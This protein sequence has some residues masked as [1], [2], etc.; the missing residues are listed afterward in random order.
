MDVERLVEDFA[1]FVHEH[2]SNMD[3]IRQR[4]TTAVGVLTHTAVAQ[5]PLYAK[6]GFLKF[7]SFSNAEIES[8][9][10]QVSERDYLQFLEAL[11][12]SEPIEVAL[13][14]VVSHTDGATSAAGATVVSTGAGGGNAYQQHGGAVGGLYDDV[15]NPVASTLGEEAFWRVG[16]LVYA[17][18]GDG[19]YYPIPFVG[20][21][22]SRTEDILMVRHQLA[23][24]EYGPVQY[25]T[26][27]FKGVV[28]DEFAP[29]DL[30]T[31][32]LTVI[33][34]WPGA[35]RGHMREAVILAKSPESLHPDGNYT[36]D[37]EWTHDSSIQ[38]DV[39]FRC[40]RL[41]QHPKRLQQELA[42]AAIVRSKSHV[43]AKSYQ[44]TTSFNSYPTKTPPTALMAS[45]S[46]IVSEIPDYIKNFVKFPH[47]DKQVQPRTLRTA[48]H[49]VAQYGQFYYDQGVK[50][51]PLVSPSQLDGS[52]AA[53]G[54]QLQHLE[55]HA[56]NTK[57]F[58][59]NPIVDIC[60][61]ACRNDAMFVDPDFPPTFY[62]ITGAEEVPAGVVW[63]R[64]SELFSKPRLF[65]VGSK[66]IDIKPGRF[67][68]PW[69]IGLFHALSSVAEIEEMISPGE[70][71]WAFGA[72]AVKLFLDGE[73]S[74]YSITGA[75]EVP[76]GVVWRRLSE[77]FSK[78]RLFSVGSKAIDIKPGRFS[79]PWL[80]GLFHA[81][82]SVAE[83]EEMIS[84]GEDG[85][86]FGAYAVKLFLDGEWSFTIVDDFVPCDEETGEPLSCT[87]GT[88]DIY[89]AILEKVLAKLAGSYS[90]LR[91]SP[92]STAAIAWEDL[93]SNIL[94]VVDHRLLIQKD[95]LSENLCALISAGTNT[96]VL[97]RVR[98]EEERFEDIG[99]LREDHWF[100]DAVAQYHPPGRR[101]AMYFFHVC[102]PTHVGREVPYVESH[103]EKFYMQFPPDAV[104]H[105]PTRGV[106]DEGIAYWI[107][108][109]D[110]YSIFDRTLTFWFYNNTQRAAIEAT[111]VGRSQAAPKM[112]G[113]SRWLA[114]PQ[115]FL[116]FVQP[117]DVIIEIKLLDRRL[118]GR[119]PLGPGSASGVPL[120]LQAHL[121]RGPPVESPL[122]VEAEYVASSQAVD[123][124]DDEEARRH[125][126][127]VI[128]ATLQGGNYVLIPSLCS[129]Q[130]NEDLL[131]KV[132]SVSAFHGKVLN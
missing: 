102:R 93:S 86:A 114:N 79:P 112:F 113:I 28:P 7:K 99:F 38:R 73:W 70:D 21:D 118:P 52:M 25:L 39:E 51:F 75:E 42:Q 129:E 68:P 122:Q 72:Y 111:F 19:C 4:V 33:A 90:E 41:L 5:Y 123:L 92:L 124:R 14:D 77:L 16:A 44:S 63:R 37:L 3:I 120:V 80:I 15:N 69:L 56:L 45:L 94:E 35:Y 85:W 108:S 131:I 88:S 117:T 78:P 23:S 13:L 81:L 64:L 6:V 101:N 76:A 71:G 29:Y 105:F 91:F 74:F 31:V 40:I 11:N 115:V 95:S 32:G 83:I 65:S 48:A 67:S 2:V 34:E 43:A 1:Q 46:P 54:F 98:G 100:V 61:E 9:L 66:A 60:D 10:E 30:V 82:S 127:A 27:G 103:K 57:Y 26:S 49:F 106:R 110:F 126:A 22:A 8:A 97:A 20:I 121:V 53:Y 96:R 130:V 116:S 87:S 84:P 18:K 17:F 132:F 89:C 50:S 104:D 119:D 62:S 12:S 128:R 109:V 24:G 58:V 47:L 59:R 55:R 107:S 36:V 125:P